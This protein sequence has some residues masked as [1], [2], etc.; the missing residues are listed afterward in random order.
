MT[1]VVSA[2]LLRM[3]KWS[4]NDEFENVIAGRNLPCSVLRYYPSVW[5]TRIEENRDTCSDIAIP[6]VEILTIDFRNTKERCH[7]SD[8]YVRPKLLITIFAPMP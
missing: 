3:V 6:W 8:S 4:A 1:S 5:P 7:P 2:V